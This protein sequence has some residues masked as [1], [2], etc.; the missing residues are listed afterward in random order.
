MTQ[1]YIY[2]YNRPYC[3]EI[4][5]YYDSHSCIYKLEEN[6]RNRFGEDIIKVRYIKKRIYIYTT[7]IFAQT[8]VAE[9]DK[10]YEDTNKF[11]ENNIREHLIGEKIKE[12]KETQEIMVETGFEFPLGSG[13][14]FKVDYI[15]TPEWNGMFMARMAGTMKYPVPIRDTKDEVM[16]LT[17]PTEIDMFYGSGLK[18]KKDMYTQT[19][20]IIFTLKKTTTLKGINDFEDPRRDYYESLL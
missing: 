7:R 2:Y 14:R 5:G 11:W 16:Y 8:E 19:A 6:L 10:I 12:I 15:A 18:F 3:D 17:D 4:E 13:H 9:M 20:S 1:E